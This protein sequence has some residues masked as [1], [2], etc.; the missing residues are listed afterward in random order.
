MDDDVNKL[1]DVAR[2]PSGVS[3]LYEA[4]GGDPSSPSLA[5]PHGRRR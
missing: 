1:T 3:T 4:T 5:C 2:S